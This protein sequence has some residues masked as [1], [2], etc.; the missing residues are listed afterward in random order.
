MSQEK[1]TAYAKLNSRVRPVVRGKRFEDPL[2]AGI[3]AKGLGHVTGGGSQLMGVNEV[4]WCGIDIEMAD[5]TKAVPFVCG[6]LT[7]LGA[8][9]GSSLN[10]SHGGRKFEVGFGA[11]EGLGLYLNGVDLPP[12]VY[13]TSDI[14]EVIQTLNT[15]LAGEG[16][17]WDTW[18]G[19][20]EVGLYM[21]GLS[22]DAMRQRIEPFVGSHPL[23]AKSRLEQ[24]A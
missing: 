12:E 6:L 5:A 9:K 8:P 11:K 7:I 4:Q 1:T 19:R 13:K 2:E 15:L 16:Q 14:N 23:C 17:I 21:Y 22:A 24:I 10:F 18:R 3:A 20:T